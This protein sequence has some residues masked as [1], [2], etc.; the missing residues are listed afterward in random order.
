MDNIV[1]YFSG[2]GNSLQVAKTIAE[3]I[4]SCKIVSMA[5]P[6]KYALEKSYNTIG[7]V[8]PTY[9]WGLPNIV[10]KFVETINLNNGK[11]AYYYAVT[12][13][14]GLVG[15]G[16]SQIKEILFDK[17][18]TALHYGMKLKMVGNHVFSYNMS[19]KI[20]KTLESS[21]KKL[22]QIIADIKAGKNNNIKKSIKPFIGLYQKLMSEV[23][24]T[25]KDY[26]INENCIKCGACVKVCPVKNIEIINGKHQFNNNCEQCLACIHYCPK[27]AINYKNVTQKR[28][29]YHNPEID[30]N[31][32]IK[33]RE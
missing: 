2:T 32:F 7:F 3:K 19:T 18:A 27:K 26:N 29:R 12:T 22:E 25:A 13:Y 24:V 31:E 17:H 9:C 8:Y 23:P 14:G 5:K 11:T 1:F 15:N 20:N 6:E 16:I 28:R 4:G 30:L 21:G 10:R 33:Y